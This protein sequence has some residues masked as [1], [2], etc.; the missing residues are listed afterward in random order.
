MM[1]ENILCAAFSFFDV[2]K[3]TVENIQRKDG[4]PFFAVAKVDCGKRDINGLGEILC[5]AEL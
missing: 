4:K 1:P 5:L 3:C 2:M